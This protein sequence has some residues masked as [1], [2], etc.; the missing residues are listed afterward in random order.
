MT[1]NDSP[2]QAPDLLRNFYDRLGDVVLIPI[3]LGQKGPRFP[4]WQKLTF[5]DTR[6]PKFQLSLQ[7]AIEHGGNLGVLLGPASDGLVAI[8]IDTDASVAA[9]LNLNPRLKE[10][11]RTHGA[12]GCQFW[13]RL[14][15]GC[16]YPNAQAVYVLKEKDGTKYGE[17]RCGGGNLGAQ[18]VLWG[19]HPQGM[20]YEIVVDKAPLVI[21]FADIRWL[22]S[23]RPGD[24]DF[25]KQNKEDLQGR[26][27]PEQQ[28]VSQDE[29]PGELANQITKYVRGCPAAKS[30]HH[31]HDLTFT[32]AC[33]LIN[34]FALAPEQA[35]PFFRIYNQRCDSP[36]TETEL[37]HKL[38]DAQ[39][40]EHKRSRGC[41]RRSQEHSFPDDELGRN[42]TFCEDLRRDYQQPIEQDQPSF[43]E[44]FSI[45]HLSRTPIP[46]EDIL[47][48]N[49]YL[50]VACI[51][52]I[53]APSGLGKSTLAIQIAILF[54]CGLTALGIPPSRQLRILIVQAEDDLG[55][56]IEMSWMI[57]HLGLS[58]HQKE[59]VGENTKLIQCNTLIAGQFVLALEQELRG[60]KSGGKPWDIVIINPYTAYLG[61]DAKDEKLCSQ[62]LC[63]QLQPVLSRYRVAAIIIHHT[64]KTNFQNTNDYK[65]WDWMYWGAGCAK[66]VNVARAILAI[67]PL[68]DEL[69]VFRFIAAKRANASE[70]SGKVTSSA[71]SLIPPSLASCAGKKLLPNRLPKPPEEAENLKQLISTKPSP[72]CPYSIRSTPR[73][74]SQRSRPPAKSEKRKPRLPSISSS[75]LAKSSCTSCHVIQP[76]ADARRKVYAVPL[77][78]PKNAFRNAPN[79]SKPL[80]TISGAEE[81][82][83]ALN[84]DQWIAENDLIEWAILTLNAPEKRIRNILTHLC[85]TK[86]LRIQTTQSGLRLYCKPTTFQG[87]SDQQLKPLSVEQ[88]QDEIALQQIE[89]VST[90]EKPVPPEW[91]E[92]LISFL[93]VQPSCKS[94][95]RPLLRKLRWKRLQLEQVLATSSALFSVST[96]SPTKQGSRPTLTIQLI[97]QP[98]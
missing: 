80:N 31:G 36:W 50:C 51:L 56:C 2:W 19:M 54:G 47:L 57:N 40:K 20:R 60:A 72:M 87:V 5:S 18:S 91:V 66:I 78:R 52:F 7:E 27:V 94:D 86:K 46:K 12:R 22:G 29:V 28:S 64:P 21:E 24:E 67:K 71:I 4:G 81:F 97:E 30:G 84:P 13:I 41:L 82:F 55:D 77:P 61:G 17:W 16:Q 49:R 25:H 96:S 45:L 34:D 92:R 48:G 3:P 53:V 1:C 58:E 79:H 75:M 62:F 85:G 65:L 69:K 68:D 95:A 83:D 23:Y 9:F 59:L 42:P 70:P 11:L 26:Q 76:I 8:D 35:L 63:Q 33:T 43:D 15:A 90:V 39:K 14:P 38:A 98:S 32:I 88:G 73:W 6:A 74:S 44:G 93:R 37:R 10:T 89:S